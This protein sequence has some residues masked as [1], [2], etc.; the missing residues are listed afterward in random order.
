MDELPD[1]GFQLSILLIVQGARRGRISLCL[2]G[3]ILWLFQ[4][5]PVY[6]GS[7]RCV[8]NLVS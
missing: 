2:L 4:A 8:S 6:L 7:F 5:S 1:P 3:G